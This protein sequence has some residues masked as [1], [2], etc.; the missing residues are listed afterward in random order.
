MNA[1]RVFQRVMAELFAEFSFV[2][3]FLDDILVFSQTREEHY[4]HLEQILEIIKNNN[5][6]IN[7]EKSVFSRKK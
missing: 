4:E 6:A 2:K 1:P 7:I 5:I 3:I